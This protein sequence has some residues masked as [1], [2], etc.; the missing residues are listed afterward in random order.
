MAARLPQALAMVLLA[1]AVSLALLTTAAAERRA[2]VSVSGA[3][4][5]ER[6]RF[7]GRCGVRNIRKLMAALSRGEETPP[8]TEPE[9]ISAQE[10]D[11]AAA[12]LSLDPARADRLARGSAGIAASVGAARSPTLVGKLRQLYREG[13]VEALQARGRRAQEETATGRQLNKVLERAEQD[14][15]GLIGGPD[16]LREV[17]RRAA[18]EVSSDGVLRHESCKQLPLQEEGSDRQNCLARAEIRDYKCD[19]HRRVSLNWQGNYLSC[20]IS[21]PVF[22]VDASYDEG[23]RQDRVGLRVP[24]EVPEEGKMPIDFAA[25]EAR[26]PCGSTPI[27]QRR[28][29]QLGGQTNHVIAASFGN[30]NCQ[31]VQVESRL[32]CGLGGDAGRCRVEAAFSRLVEVPAPPWHRLATLEEWREIGSVAVDFDRPQRVPLISASWDE[33]NCSLFDGL[34]GGS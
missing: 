1:A 27:Y 13:D 22:W 29:L 34:A 33:S 3:E 24:C 5:M 18:A 32:E 6:G 28:Q 16:R 11:C 15:Q 9:D 25:T 17:E 30:S 8:A 7:A 14:A 20:P 10:R 4:T 31:T 21:D 12:S 23:G 2:R 19:L 26:R